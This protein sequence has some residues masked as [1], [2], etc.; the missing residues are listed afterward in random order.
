[1]LKLRTMAID[2]GDHPSHLVGTRSITAVGGVLRRFKLDELPQL[3]N[4]L[5]GSMSLV[6]PRPCLPSQSELIE[7]RTRRGVFAYRP[8]IT[9]P[10]QLEGVDMSQPK[11][12]A[13]IE[14]SY[15]SSATV[16]EDIDLIWRTAMGKGAGD[17]ASKIAQ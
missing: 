9:G 3:L 17:A 1:M 14:A 2:T 5:A 16:I 7:E 6:G 10:A 11:L 12:A 8:G 4:V 13:E 15:F